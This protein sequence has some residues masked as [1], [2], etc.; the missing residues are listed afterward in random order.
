MIVS[1]KASIFSLLRWQWKST[2]IYFIFSIFACCLYFYLPVKVVLPS[3][4]LAVMG[5]AL[6]IFVSFR[7]NS[8]YSRW[9]EARQLW[10]KLINSSRHFSLQINNYIKDNSDLKSEI[11][12][13][14]ILF[15]HIFR[16]VLREQDPYKDEDVLKYLSEKD[17]ENLTGKNNINH[18]ILNFQM[19]DIRY[20]CSK[21]DITE[22]ELQSIDTTISQILDVQGGCERIKKTPMPPIY[23][24]LASRLIIIYSL[25]LP[26]TLIDS[27]GWFSIP[28]NMIVCLSFTMINEVGRILENPFTMFFNGMPLMALSKT[29]EVNLL[30]IIG[31]NEVPKIPTP[32][33]MGILM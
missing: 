16:C 28:F 6:G 14:H 27:I 4:P 23:G 25:I 33:D 29:I 19:K 9:W 12:M 10:G 18:H 22:L 26:F 11:I 21:K 24:F 5:G 3:F 7:T 13:R 1:T 2:I 32:N 20:L 31:K 15:V 17:K 8:G 30:E